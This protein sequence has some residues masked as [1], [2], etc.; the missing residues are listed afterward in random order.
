MTRPFKF[1]EDV[2]NES[3]LFAITD[4]H[5][6]TMAVIVSCMQPE[7]AAYVIEGLAPERQLTV[8]RRMAMMRQVEQVVLEIIGKDFYEQVSRQDYVNVGG[9]D[10]VAE[11]LL[12]VDAGTTRNIMENL[13]QDDPELVEV[14]KEQMRIEN[15][16]RKF[17]RK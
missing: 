8:I 14:V 3:I 5:P 11:A 1:L 12:Y 13:E 17:T 9:I 15:N 16:L 6:Q 10:T 4:E 7:Q 2:S